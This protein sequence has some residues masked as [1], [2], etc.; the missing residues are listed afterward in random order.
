MWIYRGA[1]GF[2]L[3]HHGEDLGDERVRGDGLVACGEDA[4]GDDHA[5]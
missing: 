4:G 3:R 1:E 2:H 5:G